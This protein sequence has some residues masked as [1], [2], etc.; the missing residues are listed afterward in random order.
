MGEGFSHSRGTS[1]TW[2]FTKDY[3]PGQFEATHS[4]VGVNWNL[5][6]WFR[7]LRHDYAKIIFAL[8][9]GVGEV[10]GHGRGIVSLW[11]G[12]VNGGLR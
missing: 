5:S 7:W 4:T 2:T 12:A 9:T 3:L 8:G 1:S 6:P 11:I 10:F